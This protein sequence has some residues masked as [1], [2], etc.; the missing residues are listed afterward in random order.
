MKED[1]A[2]TSVAWWTLI[3][4][5]CTYPDSRYGA[6]A[7]GASSYSLVVR[8]ATGGEEQVATW[9]S[10]PGRKVSMDGATAIPL[11]GIQ[12]LEVRDSSGAVVL[13]AQL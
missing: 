9:G 12:T 7:V 1:F 8:S 3:R 13:R 10:V 2:L 6:G 5:T 4:I 11:T